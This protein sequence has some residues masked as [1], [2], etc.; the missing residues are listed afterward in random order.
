MRIEA[1]SFRHA[2]DLLRQGVT[3]GAVEGPLPK[4]STVAKL[5]PLAAP[6]VEDQELLAR[7]VGFYAD[8]LGESPEAL[9][10]LG[11]RRIDLPE[12]V[13]TF[14]LGYANRTLGY[15]LPASNRREGADL[16]GRLQALGVF[17]ESGHEHFNGSLVVPI[18]NA[19]VV[20]E[21]YGRKIRDDLVRQAKQPTDELARLLRKAVWMG[22]GVAPSRRTPPPVDRRAG[23][24][25][26]EPSA[27]DGSSFA[28]VLTVLPVE[29]VTAEPVAVVSPA[30]GLAEGPAVLID[31]R[32]LVV[33][34]G[35][36][37]WRV[38]GLHKVS[39]FDLL[40]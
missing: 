27:D 25:D 12:A 16:R 11:R 2:V 34:F 29:P 40:R 6:S 24:L 9:A 4:V 37:R 3:S 10:Y 22:A 1:V 28:A 19:G 21:V 30:A 23:P 33:M 31:D 15:R 7:V 20:S 26:V 39:S 14:R 36:R 18:V 38:R 8:T 35:E 5:P 32:E 13:A 17:R